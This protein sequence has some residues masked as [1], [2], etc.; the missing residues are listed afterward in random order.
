MPSLG[1]RS[2]PM[3]RRAVCEGLYCAKS[4]TGRGMEYSELPKRS[5]NGNIKT[6]RAADNVEVLLSERTA[7]LEEVEEGEEPQQTL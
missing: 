5:M 1:Y 2:D 7:C 4:R 3:L 6:A